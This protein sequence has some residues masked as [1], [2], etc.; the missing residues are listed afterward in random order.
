ME[1]KGL[2]EEILDLWIFLRDN[3]LD[4]KYMLGNSAYLLLLLLE[5]L[6]MFVPFQRITDPRLD[7]PNFIHNAS[8][9]CLQ[10]SLLL[11]HTKLINKSEFPFTFF[12]LLG[13]IRHQ[14][15]GALAH[16]YALKYTIESLV[17]LLSHFCYLFLVF[18]VLAQAY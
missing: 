8:I 11:Q 15:Y 1:I 2:S 7:M 16:P 17:F 3:R 14:F 18:I 10:F 9:A 6:V 12:L 5:I 13:P 4:I